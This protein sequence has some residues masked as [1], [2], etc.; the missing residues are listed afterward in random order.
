MMKR[1]VLAMM[2]GLLIL[3]IPIASSALPTEK[4]KS[5]DVPLPRFPKNPEKNIHRVKVIGK[6]G[7]SGENQS[8]GYF[9]MVL[10]RVRKRLILVKGL[11]NTTN[12]SAKARFFGIAKRCFLNG[13]IRYDNRTIP[14]VG[15]LKIDRDNNVIRAKWMSPRESG[16]A[17]GRIS[18]HPAPS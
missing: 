17:V 1:M 4:K 13:V 5:C 3:S 10:K 12:G 16:W 7:Y 18:R 15:L 6:W 8:A 11:L 14:V 2:I 9:I